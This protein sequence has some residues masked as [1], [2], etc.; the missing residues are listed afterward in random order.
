MEHLAGTLKRGGIK[1]ML[2]F[3][4][5]NKREDK[6]FEEHFRK[7]GLPQIADWWTKKQ[8]AALKES[9]MKTLQEMLEHGD[10]HADV[11]AA[12][13]SAWPCLT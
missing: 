12:L 1:D 2:A 4:P 10:S 3:F 11:G 5:I 8:Y 9:V 7:T 6:V 13:I